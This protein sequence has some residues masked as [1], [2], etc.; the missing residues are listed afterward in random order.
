MTEKNY[1]VASWKKE[2]KKREK[3][4]KWLSNDLFFRRHIYSGV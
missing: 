4:K 2:K 3:R 1:D